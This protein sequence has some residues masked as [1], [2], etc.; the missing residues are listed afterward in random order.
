MSLTLGSHHGLAHEDQLDLGHRLALLESEGE[1]GVAVHAAA[2]AA[3]GHAGPRG[4]VPPAA[5]RA[6]RGRHH[7][8][9]ALLY[10]K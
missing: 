5:G 9:V 1:A 7:D 10:L 8:S 3:P 4:A 2:P 6:R